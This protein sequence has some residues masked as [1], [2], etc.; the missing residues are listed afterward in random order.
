MAM[1]WKFGQKLEKAIKSESDENVS[2]DG[3]F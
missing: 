3:N 1:N 2:L